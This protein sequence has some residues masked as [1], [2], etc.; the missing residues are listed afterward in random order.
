MIHWVTKFH[1]RILLEWRQAAVK[2]AL[3]LFE[4]ILLY[5]CKSLNNF[6]FTPTI[7][8]LVKISQQLQLLAAR[9]KCVIT[10]VWFCMYMMQC[11]IVIMCLTFMLMNAC[12]LESWRLRRKRTSW[13]FPSFTARWRT[14][15][16][17]LISW[18]TKVY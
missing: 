18:K 7:V 11:N 10:W 5:L 6:L 2:L 16:L 3:A 4:T 14:V 13:I 9:G 8:L 17:L 15:L 12:I 1:Y